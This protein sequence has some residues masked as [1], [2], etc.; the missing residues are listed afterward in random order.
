[1][2]PKKPNNNPDANE[3]LDNILEKYEQRRAKRLLND[4]IDKKI[5]AM[6]LLNDPISKKIKIMFWAFLGLCFFSFT[7]KFLSARFQR[8]LHEDSTDLPDMSCQAH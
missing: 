6:F 2:S 5:E 1:M 8:S 4:P 3:C 7:L